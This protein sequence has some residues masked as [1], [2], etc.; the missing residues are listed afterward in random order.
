MRVQ[1][2]KNSKSFRYKFIYANFLKE[3][4]FH[5]KVTEIK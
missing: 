5:K 3:V 1:T 4:L 2:L